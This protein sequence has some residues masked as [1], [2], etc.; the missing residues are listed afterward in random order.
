MN[1]SES[2]YITTDSRNIPY[3]MIKP[4]FVF[5]ICAVDFSAQ[6]SMDIPHRNDIVLYSDE[7]GWTMLEKKNGVATYS[8]T[9]IRRREDKD[10]Q[11]DSVRV[12]QISDIC[13]FVSEDESVKKLD[14]EL[15]TKP[16]EILE[17]AVYKKES[18]NAIYIKKFVAWKTNKEVAGFPSYI[19]YFTSYSSRSK[20]GLKT[21]MMAS[22][23][24]EQIMKLYNEMIHKNVKPGF[25]Y[26]Y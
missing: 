11:I 23:S 5:E 18:G 13:P 24:K 20:V 15:I 19:A 6:N 22:S 4:K 26:V 3:Q 9:I 21:D 25:N 1:T 14:E 10:I 16:V 17:R 2:K 12:S 7:G 8:L